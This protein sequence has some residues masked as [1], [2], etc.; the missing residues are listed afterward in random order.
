M[1]IRKIARKLR[2][3]AG[4]REKQ[5][6]AESQAASAALKASEQ[7]T[8]ELNAKEREAEESFA[9]EASRLSGAMLDMRGQ[10]RSNT[11]LERQ[12]NEHAVVR[13]RQTLKERREDHRAAVVDKH[14]MDTVT[15]E[16]DRRWADQQAEDDQRTLEESVT[17]RRADTD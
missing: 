3:I 5:R 17:S 13:E 11:S 1:K 4:V 10:C 9:Q 7:L 15:T 6:L 2:K 8:E 16:L 14:G 12:T